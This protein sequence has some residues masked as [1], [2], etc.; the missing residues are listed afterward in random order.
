MTLTIE[1]LRAQRRDPSDMVSVMDISKPKQKFGQDMF[2]L[3]PDSAG[4]AN[5]I[6]R[7]LPPTTG[8]YF[9]RQFS[10][11]IKDAKGKFHINA[12]P[13]TIGLPC[14]FC[15]NYK[16]LYNEA[17]GDPDK[18]KLAKIFR[19]SDNF[20]ANV[21]VLDNPTNYEQND[22]VLILKFG[23]RIFDKLQNQIVPSFSDENPH[24]VFDLWNGSN[25]KLRQSKVD[26]FPNFDKSC[27]DK[28]S[29]IGSDEFKVSV[30][31]Q[32]HD[33]NAKY[34]SNSSFKSYEQ[35]SSVLKTINDA[36]EEVE[37]LRKV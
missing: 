13:A 34:L 30:M 4:S 19:K 9:I 32:L 8:E 29:E 28:S 6:I 22:K 35:L 21:L 37:A 14:P 12:C 1:S 27:F 23:K 18:Q 26:G 16:R 15:E 5:A 7:F 2:K 31:S 11:V 33:L 3:I 24:N 20:Y 10:H 36:A 17:I 25:F